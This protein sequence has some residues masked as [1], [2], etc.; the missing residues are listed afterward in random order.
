[1]RSEQVSMVDEGIRVV[2]D[3]GVTVVKWSELMKGHH[4]IKDGM[5][6]RIG[7][8]VG[9]HMEQQAANDE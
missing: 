1:M 7:I 5:A 3:S 6:F 4:M 2:S 9:M 8:R